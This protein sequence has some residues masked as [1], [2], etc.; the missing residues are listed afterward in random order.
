[1]GL[2]RPGTVSSP[3]GCRPCG[4]VRRV[5]VPFVPSLCHQ[6]RPVRQLYP[7]WQR[8]SETVAGAPAGLAPSGHPCWVMP[9]GRRGHT[10]EAGGSSSLTSDCEKARRDRI[11]T[12][13]P[14]A[15]APRQA[16]SA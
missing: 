12:S 9:G 16:G 4:L 5:L 1:M 2:Y 13:S 15:L 10:V 3:A 14:A 11:A 8:P 7:L 6:L